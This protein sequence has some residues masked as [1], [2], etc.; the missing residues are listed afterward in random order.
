MDI[1]SLRDNIGIM[2][3]MVTCSPLYI[4]YSGKE[5]PPT[6]GLPTTL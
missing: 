2:L 1:F 3:V 5:R 6:L 4:T